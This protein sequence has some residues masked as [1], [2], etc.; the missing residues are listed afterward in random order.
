M[1]TN[2][3]L[4]FLILSIVSIQNISIGSATEK[5]A[6]IDSKI[7]FIEDRIQSSY[8][9]GNDSNSCGTWREDYISLQS[10]L[11]GETTSSTVKS[12]VLVPHTS[13]IADRILGVASAF[14]IGLITNRTFQIAQRDRL[15]YLD[16]VFRPHKISWR[17]QRDPSWLIDPLKEECVE[18]EGV[19]CDQHHRKQEAAGHDEYQTVLM[20]VNKGRVLKMFDNPHH[21]HRIQSLNMS[22]GAAFGCIVDF[23]FAPHPHIFLPLLR[24]FDVMTAHSSNKEDE[25]LKIGIQ[26]YMFFDC[27]E[28]IEAFVKL[29]RNFSRVVWYLLTESMPLRLAA[30]K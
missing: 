4:I 15:P 26:F 22:K 20:S 9:I 30:V 14:F 25:V 11:N 12:L 8:T 28:Q 27:A 23:L 24:E 2:V 29:E 18:L 10:S 16:L 3:L 19:Q 7:T 6:T 1:I 21:I 17:R 13:G 5:F